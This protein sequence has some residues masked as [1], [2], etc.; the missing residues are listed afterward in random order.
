MEDESFIVIKPSKPFTT[1]RLL[2]GEFSEAESALKEGM[3]KLH[4]GRWAATSPIV[5]IHPMDK[6]NGGLSQVEER[7]LQ[8]VAAGAG[9][10][11]AYIWVGHELSKEEVLEKV[12]E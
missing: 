8:E 10:R 5:V 3:K 11:K 6:T 2:I 1:E 4:Y 12:S 9:A 7:V